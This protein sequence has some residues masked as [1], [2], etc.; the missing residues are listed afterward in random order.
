MKIEKNSKYLKLVADEG[1][2]LTY[3]G[4]NFMECAVPVD[5]DLTKIKEIS[6]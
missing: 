3:K 5:F 1:K 2:V 6:Q 4:M